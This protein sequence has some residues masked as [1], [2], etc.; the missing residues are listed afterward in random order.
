MEKTTI[1]FRSTT[2]KTIDMILQKRKLIT[3]VK[4]LK[5][6]LI[7]SN[8]FILV[9]I[10]FY[11]CNK[12]S[13]NPIK[14]EEVTPWCIVNFD[15]LE[16]SPIERIQ[17]LK[18]MGFKKYGYNWDN[19]HLDNLKEE[20]TLAKENNIEIT[21]IFL[22]LN[23]KRDSIG[24]LSPANERML[25][26]LSEV[27]YKPTIWLSFSDNFFKDRT[28]EQSLSKAIEFIKYIKI[29]AD[30]IGCKIALYNHHGWFGNPYNQIE[31]IEAL[32]NYSLSMVY[33][34][35]HAHQY[36]DD[37]EKIAKKIK[38]YLSYVNINGMKR[39]GPKILTIGDGDHEQEMIKIFI[40]EGFKGPWGILGHIKT[41]DVQKVLERNI[42]GI[43]SLNLIE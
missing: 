12:K 25:D 3:A 9:L 33:N 1:T 41:E 15:S 18:N 29:K 27:D 35:H 43:K 7:K 19:K 4:R 34:F 24:K 21:S 13:E 31:I 36:L 32:P 39:E 30:K 20:F 10:V 26:L 23:A 38:H 22:W 17:M 40:E 14:I 11:A 8:L 28:Q 2:V 16:R 6:S 42:K 37:F 5:W